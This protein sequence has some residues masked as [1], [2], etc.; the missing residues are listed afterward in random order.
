MC[1]SACVC[2]RGSPGVGGRGGGGC[3]VT[4]GPVASARLPKH[5]QAVLRSSSV[6]LSGYHLY[7]IIFCPLDDVFPF[8]HTLRTVY[9]FLQCSLTWFGTQ[10]SALSPSKAA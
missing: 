1:M 7:F 3:S 8:S 2:A 5:F 4:V 6:T 10:L 9:T